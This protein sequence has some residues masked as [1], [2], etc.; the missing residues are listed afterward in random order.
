M[1]KDLKLVLSKVWAGERRIG[2]A[3]ALQAGNLNSIPDITTMGGLAG[4][5][6]TGLLVIPLL[7]SD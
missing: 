3:Y 2:L 6:M 1:E 5:E 4:P 7:D